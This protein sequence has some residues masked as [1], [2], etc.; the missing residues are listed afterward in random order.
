MTPGPSESTYK[1]MY[2]SPIPADSASGPSYRRFIN[3]LASVLI[4]CCSGSV[5]AWS[6]FVSPLKTEFGLSTA[7][8]QLIFGFIIASFSFTMLF[9]SR[10]EKKLGPKF[11]A[12]IG[13][14]LFSSG[15][16]LASFT[17]GGVLQILLGISILSGAGMG[18]GYITV[19]TTL[20]KWF[21][22]RQGL[23]TGI[24]V[25]GFGSGAILLSQIVH[26]I[27]NSGTAVDDVFR[28]I[29]IIYGALFLIGA[30]SISAPSII[31]EEIGKKPISLV[32]LLKDRHFWGLFLAYFAGS[33][34]GLMLIGNLKPMGISYGVSEGAATLSIVLISVGNATG[35]IMWG[36]IFD[37][38]GGKKSVITALA[39]LAAFTLILI[40]GI[41]SNIGFLLLTLVI[42]LCFG[43][44]FVLYASEISYIYGVHRL[45]FVY[46]IV[47]LAYG[48]SGI[49][50]PLVGGRIYDVTNQYSIPVIIAAGI[51]LAGLIPY[52]L[53]MHKKNDSFD[54][55]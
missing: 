16:L 1:H 31:R 39:L 27:L 37:I 11:T 36:Q 48:I 24:A 54:T 30:L 8:T 45:G 26:P 7:Q 52:I 23:A 28:I 17:D 9:V 14:V 32:I 34:A 47:S 51:C 42:G 20:V 10:I 35:R 12:A 53:F 33:F 21:P 41:S 44:N 46:P 22:D 6:V 3:I 5:Y 38:F 25:A 40:A 13:A 50:G 29:G 2:K 49:A 4:M 18:F 15:Y 19:L 43:A 55:I